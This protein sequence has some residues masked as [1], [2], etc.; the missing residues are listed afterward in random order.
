MPCTSRPRAW[1]HGSVRRDPG[2]TVRPEYYTRWNIERRWKFDPRPSALQMSSIDTQDVI[3]FTSNIRCNVAAY[4]E[5]TPSAWELMLPIEYEDFSCTPEDYEV[6]GELC[7]QFYE[8]LREGITTDP[9]LIPGTQDQ[10]KSDVWKR[11]RAL[12]VTASNAKT[13]L[14]LKSKSAKKNYLRRELWGMWPF[15]GNTATKYGSRNE[16]KARQSYEDL[17]KLK[18]PRLSVEPTGLWVNKC[19]PHLGCSPDGLVKTKSGLL[20]K[21]VEIKCPHILRKCKPQDYAQKLTRSQKAAFPLTTNQQGVIT[22]KKTHSHYLQMQ[23]QMDVMRVNV[24]DYVV[25]TPS[26]FL[27]IPIKYDATFWE[28][29]R[30]R[31]SEIH[32]E[33]IAVDYFLMKTPRGLDPDDASVVI[34]HSERRSP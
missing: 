25:W 23:F 7:N 4:P 11:H 13:L 31:L 22:V 29:K 30:K 14:G 24:C 19:L 32:G 8:G 15:K 27:K 34:I 18:D 10:A 12:I 3:D 16:E 9:Y 2:P 6:I 20:I 17:L 21:I 28:H 33:L 26:G 1:G 5:S